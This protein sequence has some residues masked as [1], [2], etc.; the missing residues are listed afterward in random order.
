L[1][2]DIVIGKR[3][4]YVAA[5]DLMDPL[6]N[7]NDPRK[8]LFFGTNN[9][10][11]YVGGIVGK[12]NTFSDVSKPAAN[13]YAATAPYVFADYV[14]TEFLRAEAKER[15]YTVAGTAEQHYNNAITASIVY[16]GGSATDAATYLARPDVA[17]TTATGNYKQKIGFQKWIGLYGRPFDG[18]VELR[19]LD[20]PQLPLALNNKT[21]FPNR[22]TYPLNEQQLNGTNYTAAASAIGGDKPETK[23][24]WDKF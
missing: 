9:N 18:W 1:Y 2:S 8:S 15:G 13:V 11:A 6:I 5:K 7:M 17:Y 21:P 12:A 14:E 20:Y 19:R 22:F 10:G 24:F 4:D 23:L 16:W 3:S